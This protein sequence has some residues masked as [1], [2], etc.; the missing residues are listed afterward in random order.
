MASSDFDNLDEYEVQP[1]LFVLVRAVDL[2]AIKCLLSSP[3]EGNIRLNVRDVARSSAARKGSI[4][5]PQLVTPEDEPHLA[6]N[7]IIYEVESADSKFF[8]WALERVNPADIDT[9]NFNKTMLSTPSDE[10]YS[11]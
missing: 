4:A 9:G 3:S 10:I 8:K 5:I 2:E 6:T 1:L 7:I 11:I